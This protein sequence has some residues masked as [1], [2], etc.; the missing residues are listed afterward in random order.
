MADTYTATSTYTIADVEA[1]FRR[2]RADI[3]M[4]ADSTGAITREEA[5]KYAHD[6]EYLAKRGYLAK[7]DVT[8]L[9]Y[10]VEKH[11]TVYQVNDKAG[12][13]TSSRPGG[14]L[15]PRVD[16]ARLR[17]LLFYT[18]AYTNDARAKVRPQLKISWTP[19]GEDASH[20]SLTPSATRSYASNGYGLERNDLT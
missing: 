1:V 8:L 19:S 17:V 20:A 14:V 4:I 6:A 9:S 5:E 10:G 11:A 18:A 16:G 2:F 13:L 12:D 15:W 7:V 3:I